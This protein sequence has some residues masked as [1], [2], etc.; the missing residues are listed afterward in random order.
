[1]EGID[2]VKYDEALGLEGTGYAT[3][4]ACAAGYRSTADK[5][6]S[7]PKFRYS[8]AELIQRI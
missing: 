3:K 4:V 1:M 2:P 7:L 6:A 8:Q 5:Y